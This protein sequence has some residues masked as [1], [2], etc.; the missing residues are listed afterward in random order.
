MEACCGIIEVLSQNFP[1]GTEEN[2]LIQSQN[3]SFPYEKLDHHINTQI[4]IFIHS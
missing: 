4:S 2:H 3:I 1:G